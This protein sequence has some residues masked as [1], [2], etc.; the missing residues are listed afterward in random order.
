MNKLQIIRVS[1]KVTLLGECILVF[2]VFINGI[3]Y[4]IPHIYHGDDVDDRDL[5]NLCEGDDLYVRFY[6]NTPY[7]VGYEKCNYKYD[8]STDIKCKFPGYADFV[9][10]YNTGKIHTRNLRHIEVTYARMRTMITRGMNWHSPISDFTIYILGIDKSSMISDIFKLEN[11]KQ[12]SMLSEHRI[13]DVL[14]YILEALPHDTIRDIIHSMTFAYIP[15][16]YARTLVNEFITYNK[17]NCDIIHALP[18][19][20]DSDVLQLLDIFSTTYF[21]HY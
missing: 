14:S 12:L 7:I 5:I 8:E 21:K 3:E 2:H 10:N 18:D 9:V 6:N 4:E 13:A 1:D 19:P 11:I 15:F 20:V 17:I 16:K